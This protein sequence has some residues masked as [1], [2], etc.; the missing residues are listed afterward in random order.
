MREIFRRACSKSVARFFFR[1][2]RS[3]R[4]ALDTELPSDVYILRNSV[5][6]VFCRRIRGLDFHTCIRNCH[7]GLLRTGTTLSLET[8]VGAVSLY[9][10]QVL[11]RKLK[12]ITNNW[13]QLARIEHYSNLPKTVSDNWPQLGTVGDNCTKL[14]KI[15]QN[16]SQF[17]TIERNWP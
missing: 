6:V 9:R 8:L 15:E 12:E 11:S 2:Y 4:R 5:G 13:R 16:R 3:A 7:F 14:N 17:N 10:S 1:S